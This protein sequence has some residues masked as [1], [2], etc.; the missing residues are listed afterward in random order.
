MKFVGVGFYNGGSASGLDG[1]PE[2]VASFLCPCDT[3]VEILGNSILL[4]TQLLRVILKEAERLALQCGERSLEV[5][6]PLLGIEEPLRQSG[7][8]CG[9]GVKR[10][11]V[12]MPAAKIELAPVLLIEF[13]GTTS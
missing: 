1:S 11:T 10:D 8:G 12:E 13:R 3:L 4:V 9:G 2:C 7:K 6:P 5:L